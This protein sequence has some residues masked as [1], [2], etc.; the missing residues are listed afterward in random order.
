MYT[1]I[2][3]GWEAHVHTHTYV[4]TKQ[5]QETLHMQV[6]E[7]IEIATDAIRDIHNCEAIQ[8]F[9]LPRFYKGCLTLTTKI[10]SY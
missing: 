6:V 4:S 3:C 5:F 1:F 2:A 8:V 7:K 10:I 9:V